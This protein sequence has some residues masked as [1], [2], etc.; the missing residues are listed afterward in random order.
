MRAPLTETRDYILVHGF[1]YNDYISELTKPSDIGKPQFGAD[2]NKAFA[3]TYFNTRQFL[4][5]GFGLTERESISVMSTSVDFGVTQVVDSNWGAHGIIYK[6]V[7][8][9]KTSPAG[10][11]PLMSSKRKLL[12]SAAAAAG[13]EAYPDMIQMMEEALAQR[14]ADAREL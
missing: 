5:D 3:N 11:I 2:L 10:G 7:F 8:S 13:E 14:A 12:E 6:S 4:I 1:A 9:K